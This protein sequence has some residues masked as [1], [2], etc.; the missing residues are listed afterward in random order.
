MFLSFGY[1]T[2]KSFLF[3]AVP[4]I[5]IIRRYFSESMKFTRAKNMFYVGF[6]QLIGKSIN[7]ILWLILEKTT[8]PDKNENQEKK[9]TTKTI[10]ETPQN[11]A[12]NQYEIENNE[13]IKKSKLKKKLLLLLVCVL[14]FL[15]G[16]SNT[17]IRK[18][19]LF[20][21]RTVCLISLTVVIR[22]FA[23]AILSYI[24]IKNT[25]L[26]RH[27]YLSIVI[28]LIVE[29]VTHIISSITEDYTDYF[30]KLGLMILP[31]L[32]YSI[33]YVC[34]SKYL[35]VTEG[36]IF[37]LLFIDGVIGMILSIIL[38]IF[39][40]FLPCYHNQNENDY[41]PFIDDTFNCDGDK[42]K[43]MLKNFKEKEFEI[44]SSIILI[45]ANFIETWLIWFLIYSFSV[46]HFGAVHTIPLFFYFCIKNN[47]EKNYFTT[48]NLIM[49]ILGGFI[50][51]FM[52]FVYNE[53]LILKF[54][55]LDKNTAIE[56]NKR[57]L[58]D[59]YCDY[60]ED[61][62]DVHTK[63]NENYLILQDDLEGNNDD[64]EKHS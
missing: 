24:I 56:I 26:Y 27:H 64:T 38:Q 41:G 33:M 40:F 35:L 14:N 8:K 52:T 1:L 16:I 6:I 63:V 28:I 45:F 55:Y 11:N 3:L 30:P 36:N 18:T 39:S 34:G 13:K 58:E 61:K 53:I 20:S 51:I 49:L 22:L 17:I 62:D 32:L 21:E 47:K 46:N 19:K 60:G 2:K 15:A 9:N 5:I 7:G 10:L 57:A 44:D 4:V 43:T 42:L 29:L 12:Y 54:L 31:E 25:K 59:V 48:G 23:I 50:I 37:K